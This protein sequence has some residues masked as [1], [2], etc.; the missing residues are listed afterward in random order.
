MRQHSEGA[1]G[2]LGDGRTTFGHDLVVVG[3]STGGVEA[4]TYLV[5]GLPEDLPASMCVVMHI[6]AQS[7]SYLPQ[8]LSR[9]GPLP[10]T[11]AMD[12]EPLAPGHI[13]VAP[14]DRHLLVEHGRLRLSRG[15]KE[16][17]ARPA[18]DPLFRSA[19]L[20]YGPRVIGMVLTGALDDGTSGLF[21]V[22]E[23]GGIAVVQD[24]EDALIPSMPASA[25]EYVDVDHCVP[26]S[27][28]PALLTRLVREPVD[29]EAAGPVPELLR[30]EANM[31]EMDEGT[32]EQAE[33]PGALSSLTCPDCGGPIYELRDGKLIRFRC[34]SGHAFTYE[35]MA[36]GQAE[37]V[38]E[39]LWVAVNTLM[40]SCQLSERLASDAHNRGHT[41]I[42]KRFTD[43]A[44]EM[45]RRAELLRDV[46]STD[47]RKVPDESDE[48]AA[49]GTAAEAGG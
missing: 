44:G 12:G 1:G 46:L 14:P 38:E 6:P 33:T 4:L 18:V 5:H 22:K 20:A 34:R 45:Q 3:A 10:A 41:R 17:R 27:A 28:M 13:Y 47:G 39:A 43:R 8:I 35:T 48:S 15:P 16:N 29:V 36:A 31:A 40:E 23:R 26:L 37:A 21:S 2:A 30:Y 32:M 19:A 24:P 7:H 49:G 42:A 11:H 25:F 9:H